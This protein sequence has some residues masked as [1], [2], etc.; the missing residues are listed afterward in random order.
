MKRYAL[1]QIPFFV[2][3]TLIP[4]QPNDHLWRGGIRSVE[5]AVFPNGILYD[6]GNYPMLVEEEGGVVRGKLISVVNGLY[7]EILSR[8]DHLEGYIP[9][10]PSKSSY[11][12]IKREVT[13]D[14]G[15]RS[16]SWLY[17]GRQ[18]QAQK[19]RVIPGGDWVLYAASRRG[20]IDNWWE[21]IDTVHGLHNG[22]EGSGT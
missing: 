21:N 7:E 18:K 6:M 3:G 15:Q 13:T 2:Y 20:N 9:D 8:L 14:K 10:Q 19:R 12:R 1:A 17:I 22:A 16:L 11:K 5:T 4:G